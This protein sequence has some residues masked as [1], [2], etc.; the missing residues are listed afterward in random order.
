MPSG[1]V[2]L[3]NKVSTDRPPA[4]VFFC[5]DSNGWK[6]LK[7]V[8]GFCEHEG[9]ALLAVSEIQV[10]VSCADCKKIRLYDT[11]SGDR[12]TVFES[13]FF[14]PKQMCYAE[15]KNIFIYNATTKCSGT[16]D[17]LKASKTAFTVLTKNN[18]IWNTSIPE[19]VLRARSE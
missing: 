4:L 1:I 19:H 16:V 11:I 14:K 2:I 6:M 17:L 7:K 3:W 8:P 12:T 9:I 13:S 15:A 10:A 5:I 18:N